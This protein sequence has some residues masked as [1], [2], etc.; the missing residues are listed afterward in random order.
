MHNCILTRF[1]A[2]NNLRKPFNDVR[3]RR[4]L[5]YAI[6]KEAFA[7][8]VYSG[9]ADPMDSPMPP[10]MAFYVKQGAW[11]YDPAKAKTLPAEVGYPM[12]SNPA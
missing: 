1:V 5:N 11:P 10:K 7:R 3:V 9:H 6:D 4:A 12:G 2:L 8:V